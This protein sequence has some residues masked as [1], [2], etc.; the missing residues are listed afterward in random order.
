MNR[1]NFPLVYVVSDNFDSF[2]TQ[3]A[4][5]EVRLQMSMGDFHVHTHCDVIA[6]DP[7][8]FEATEEV[9]DLDDETG[10][11]LTIGFV[12]DFLKGEDK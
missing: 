8:S 9:Y 7:M 2:M 12:K 10:E 3:R 5:K 11:I 1:L 6:V 4:Y